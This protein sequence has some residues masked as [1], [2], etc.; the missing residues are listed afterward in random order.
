LELITPH[1]DHS[2][3]V[4]WADSDESG[5]SEWTLIEHTGVLDMPHPSMS[6]ADQLQVILFG[7]GET[8]IDD[9]EVL[10]NGQ[11]RLRNPRFETNALNWVGQGTHKATA[12]QTNSGFNGGNALRVSASDRG[13]QVANRV[14]GALTPAIAIGTEVTLRGRARWLKGNTDLLLR[15][16]SGMLEAPGRLSI[17]TALGTP[18]KRKQPGAS[19]YWASHC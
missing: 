17:P 7:K 5:K 3:G 12:W 14:R 19:E 1:S 4:S 13:D 10:V 8:L 11:N 2:L 15:L 16:R 18:G 6:T 9:M